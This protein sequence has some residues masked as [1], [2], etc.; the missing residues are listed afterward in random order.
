MLLICGLIKVY[1][2][3]ISVKTRIATK[4]KYINSEN[5]E[6]IITTLMKCC[7]NETT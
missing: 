6:K 3:F 2:E 7:R 1:T 5:S 4:Q